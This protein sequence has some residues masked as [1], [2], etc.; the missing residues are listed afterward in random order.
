MLRIDLLNH[1]FSRSLRGYNP[2][3]VEAFLQDIADTMAKMSDEKVKLTNKIA[4]LEK[5]V[6]IFAQ[7]EASMRETL[8]AS[9]KMADNI[10]SQAQK[11]AML[12]I[13]AAQT[14][15]ENL[16]TQANIRLAK[17]LEEISEAR[18]LKAQFEFKV[19]S[20][21]ESHLKLLELGQLEDERL[22]EL[23]AQLETPWKPK[24]SLDVE[25]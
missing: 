14:K 13:E 22:E 17:I 1:Q 16:T 23:S 7:R 2:E 15:S 8:V 5:Q 3:E 24:K 6:K 9:Q 25:K 20:V 21:I 11:E 10:K 18:R 12:I 19:R 4:K